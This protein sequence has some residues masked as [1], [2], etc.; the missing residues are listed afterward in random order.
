MEEIDLLHLEHYNELSDF[1]FSEYNGKYHPIL[2]LISKVHSTILKYPNNKFVVIIKY[3]HINGVGMYLPKEYYALESFPYQ[4]LI[5]DVVIDVCRISVEEL[6][7]KSYI[8]NKS[9]DYTILGDMENTYPNLIMF[10]EF[11][12][13]TM[14]GTI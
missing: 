6:G 14:A 5:D 8:F 3:V 1:I 9:R 4:D 13:N 12:V 11:F 2:D 7:S 10:D